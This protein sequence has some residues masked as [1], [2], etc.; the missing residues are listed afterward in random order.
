MQKTQVSSCLILNRSE[1]LSHDSDRDRERTQLG[2][3][4]LVFFHA[5][6]V[7]WEY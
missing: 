1:L 7:E 5:K 2:K 6:R 3:L 4:M